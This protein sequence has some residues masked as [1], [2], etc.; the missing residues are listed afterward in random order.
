MDASQLKSGDRRFISV[1]IPK[2]TQ[3]HFQQFV[4]I[5]VW[6]EESETQDTKLIRRYWN[7]VPGLKNHTLILITAIAN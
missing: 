5:I 4:E 1:G 2:K 6:F 7:W 3:I